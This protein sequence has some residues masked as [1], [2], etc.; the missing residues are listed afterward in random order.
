MADPWELVLH[1]TYAGTPGVILDHSPSRRSHGQPVNLTE[2][3]FLTDGVRPG[4]GAVRFDSADEH[5]PRAALGE[6]GPT[7]WHTN[8]NGV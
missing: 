1:H 5:D 6:L 8:R 7:G 4:S 2:A 3:D